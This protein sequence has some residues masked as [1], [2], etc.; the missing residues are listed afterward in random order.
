MLNPERPRLSEELEE[1][2]IDVDRRSAQVYDAL[3]NIT[4][5][6]GDAAKKL[7]DGGVVMQ[8]L[9]PSDTLVTRIEVAKEAV[10][11]RMTPVGDE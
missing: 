1:Q 5:D 7:R 3:E 4:D 8:P 11:R 6:L 2:F 10:K 9:P